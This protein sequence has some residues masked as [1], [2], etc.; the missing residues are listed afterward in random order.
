MK[1]KYINPFTDYGFEKLFGQEGSKKFLINF[2][3]DILPIKDKLKELNFQKNEQ[4]G[5]SY[6]NRK[7]IYD[8]FTQ[9]KK[10]GGVVNDKRWI[11]K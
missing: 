9:E 4:Q 3:N 5:D 2:L 6:V 11:I 7:A 1:S 8:L 10:L